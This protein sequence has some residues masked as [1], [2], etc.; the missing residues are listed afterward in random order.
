LE[1]IQTI[2][3]QFRPLD[4]EQSKSIVRVLVPMIA[5]I[6]TGAI[7]PAY[8][9]S[10]I[11]AQKQIERTESTRYNNGEMTAQEEAIYEAKIMGI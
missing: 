8:K 3:H 5:K 1:Q 7:N 9:L 6:E 4:D 11:H 10:E 2:V